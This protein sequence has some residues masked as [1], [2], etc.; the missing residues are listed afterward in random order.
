MIK[1]LKLSTLALLPI[2]FN[3]NAVE[4][5]DTDLIGKCLNLKSA[6]TK[7]FTE[8]SNLSEF[9][10]SFHYQNSENGF[11]GIC[12]NAKIVIENNGLKN[13]EE[14][15]RYIFLWSTTHG[16]ESPE[17]SVDNVQYSTKQPNDIQAW[18]Q[19]KV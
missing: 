6:L 16:A 10:A 1:L 19:E 17:L 8:G 5:A 2:M 14:N 7:A 3:V 9:N 13:S 12:S 15:Q 4:T 11:K 18:L